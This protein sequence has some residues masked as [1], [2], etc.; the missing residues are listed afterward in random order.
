MANEILEIF[1][2]DGEVNLDLNA[3]SESSIYNPKPEGRESY[4]ATLRFLPIPIMQD[5]KMVGVEA[6]PYYMKKRYYLRDEAGLGFYFD[7][8]IT[9]KQKCPISATYYKLKNSNNVYDKQKAEEFK[10]NTHFWGLVLIID[11]KKNPDLNGKIKI[12]R[13]TSEI[14]EKIQNEYDK[15][16]IKVWDPFRGKDFDLTTT[17]KKV[18]FKQSNGTEVVREIQD[19][20]KSEFLE[21]CA[22][23]F[24][25]V[26]F[27]RTNPKIGELISEM[28]AAAPEMGNIKYRPWNSEEREK[29]DKILLRYRT[30]DEI[31]QSPN[32]KSEQSNST[33]DN[34]S[35]QSLNLDADYDNENMDELMSSLGV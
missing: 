1:N 25:G 4:I 15:R 24:K 17:N 35:E 11:D 34:D 12:M 29:L 18:T 8:P 30:F 5:G 10:I 19:Y 23:T 7:S 33:E 9:V 22:M 6:E 20:S 26:T 14:H 27:D 32:V 31:R 16:K 28:Y 13:F 21:T 3:N 2:L